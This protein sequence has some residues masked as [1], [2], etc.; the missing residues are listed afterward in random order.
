M[1]RSEFEVRFLDR[2]DVLSV[3]VASDKNGTF[4]AE[5]IARSA[6]ATVLKVK[7]ACLELF[8]LKS[9]SRAKSHLGLRQSKRAVCEFPLNR[10]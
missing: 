8:A 5:A 1:I 4:T 10:R 3:E 7:P 2:P 6:A 9:G